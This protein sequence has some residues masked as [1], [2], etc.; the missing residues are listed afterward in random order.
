MS[1]VFRWIVVRLEHQ[2]LYRLL[3]HVYMM[4]LLHY[5]SFCLQSFV[6]HRI[7]IGPLGPASLL[8]KLRRSDHAQAA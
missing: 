2:S 6:S 1:F 4:D 8:V 5:R 3:C 7:I